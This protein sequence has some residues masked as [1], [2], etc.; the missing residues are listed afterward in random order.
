MRPRSDPRDRDGT[1]NYG[2]R[3]RLQGPR[4]THRP[5]DN[6]GFEYSPIRH[7]RSRFTPMAPSPLDLHSIS[8]RN[9]DRRLMTFPETTNT[10]SPV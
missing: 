2:G 9:R 3:L 5:V 6:P 1:C 10:P 8:G 7:A 4:R